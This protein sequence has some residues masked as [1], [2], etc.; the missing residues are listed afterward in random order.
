[1]RLILIFILIFAL[2]FFIWKNL[3]LPKSIG[4][5]NGA[6]N[7]CPKSPNCVS[8]MDQDEGHY[9]Q[10]L[11]YQSEKTLDIIWQYLSDVYDAQL[12]SKTSNYLHVVVTT[13]KLRFKDDLEFLVDKKAMVVCVRSASRL[14]YS[15]MKTN[16]LRIEKLREF[17]NRSNGDLEKKS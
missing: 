1:M 14:G 2:G 15:D 10:P 3:T 8:C 9:I 6:L 17:L 5:R 12:I 13:K 4:I 7:L 11:P 16:R